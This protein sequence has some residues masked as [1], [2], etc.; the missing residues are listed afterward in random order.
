MSLD[1][2]IATRDG[3]YD[4]IIMD[5]GIDF[6]ALVAEL[7][8]LIAARPLAY[9]PATPPETACGGVPWD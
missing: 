9:S 6:A 4:W 3:G 2:Y 7:D 1:G 8:A 5:P